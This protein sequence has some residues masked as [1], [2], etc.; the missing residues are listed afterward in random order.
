MCVETDKTLPR[1]HEENVYEVIPDYL[2]LSAN[3]RFP[4]DGN[5][6]SGTAGTTPHLI[7]IK[8][9]GSYYNSPNPVSMINQECIHRL[10]ITKQA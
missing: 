9:E 8:H 4:V 7:Q 2:I 3:G 5:T 1:D 10:D 6:S